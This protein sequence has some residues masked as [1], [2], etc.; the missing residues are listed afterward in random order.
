M[1]YEE[2]VDYLFSKLPMFHRIGAAAYKPDIG[3]ISKLCDDLGNKILNEAFTNIKKLRDNYF[4]YQVNDSIGLACTK[5]GKLTSAKY[6]AIEST[7]ND[8]VFKVF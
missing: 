8:S 7:K 4:T 5:K 6:D 3:N 2:A 1:N